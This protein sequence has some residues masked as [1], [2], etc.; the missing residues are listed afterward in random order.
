MPGIGP[1]CALERGVVPVDE[2]VVR[3]D[4]IPR[5]D[6]VDPRDR[7]IA[8]TRAC[9]LVGVRPREVDSPEVLL[10]G[11]VVN[12]IVRRS[13]EKE[14]ATLFV[15]ARRHRVDVHSGGSGQDDSIDVAGGGKPADLAVADRTVR[16]PEVPV[17]HREI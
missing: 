6:Q 9:D 17:L 1:D 12:R 13:L 2:G 7:V 15:P 5:G 8:D 3:N 14:N 16:G 10:G 4:V 11:H